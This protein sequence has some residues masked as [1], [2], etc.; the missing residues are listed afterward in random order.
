MK[1]KTFLTWLVSNLKS[2][3]VQPGIMESG[4]LCEHF[5]K[6]HCLQ[7][8]LL[9]PCCINMGFSLQLLKGRTSSLQVVLLSSNQDHADERISVAV[10]MHSGT[11]LVAIAT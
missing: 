7:Q 5:S 10:L 2:L 4:L 9:N 8:A 11:P 6:P 1:G 3:T